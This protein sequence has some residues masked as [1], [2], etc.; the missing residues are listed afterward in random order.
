ML[1]RMRYPSLFLCRL[2]GAGNLVLYMNVFQVLFCYAELR[3][4]NFTL[5]PSFV[6]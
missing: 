5:K 6:T 1:S 4:K 2:L 3:I